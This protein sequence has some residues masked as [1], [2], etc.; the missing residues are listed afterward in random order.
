[1]E[2]N[3]LFVLCSLL[4]H[5]ALA[6]KDLDVVNFAEETVNPGS[7]THTMSLMC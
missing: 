6:T 2:L 7:K 5:K 1:M 3:A 4:F